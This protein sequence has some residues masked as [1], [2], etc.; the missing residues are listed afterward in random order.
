MTNISVLG[1]TGSIG[2]QVLDV[3]KR[4]GNKV[5]VLALGA[6]NNAQ[7]LIEQINEWKPKYAC[8][9]NEDLYDYVR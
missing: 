8:I 6:Q 7:R 1:S 9:G 5:Q 4:I 3:C 2:T